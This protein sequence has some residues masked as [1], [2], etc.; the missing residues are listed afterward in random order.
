MLPEYAK[1]VVCVVSR[2][3]L[4]MTLEWVVLGLPR[5]FCYPGLQRR[6]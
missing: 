4:W 5:L 3:R 6:H 2:G 1:S